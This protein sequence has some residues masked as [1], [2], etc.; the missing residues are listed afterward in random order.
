[1]HNKVI[2][3]NRR[4]QR[5][6][7]NVRRRKLMQQV[8]A[9][10]YPCCIQVVKHAGCFKLPGK[11]KKETTN[12]QMLT[13]ETIGQ[14]SNVCWQLCH[15][16]RDP[17]RASARIYKLYKGL[18]NKYNVVK[19]YS[20]IHALYPAA[21]RK[22]ASSAPAS[23]SSSLTIS[24]TTSITQSIQGAYDILLV[25]ILIDILSGK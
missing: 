8:S 13:D 7:Y 25:A 12:I 20:S 24:L 2:E 21:F 22:G 10:I 23:S 15:S 9:Y 4:Q 17:L 11:W 14:E 16:I 1:M 18:S 19:R 3:L 5:R 6:R